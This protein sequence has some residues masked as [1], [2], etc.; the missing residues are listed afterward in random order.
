MDLIRRRIA[1]HGTIL[2]TIPHASAEDGSIEFV[3]VVTT[4]DVVGLEIRQLHVTVD[5][6]GEAPPE[7]SSTRRRTTCSGRRTG[8]VLPLRSGG[9]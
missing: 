3:F 9:A 4:T 5:S 6:I 1:E 7:R 2:E 8:C